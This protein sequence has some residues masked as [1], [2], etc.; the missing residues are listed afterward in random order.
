MLYIFFLSLPSSDLRPLTSDFCLPSFYSKDNISTK[1]WILIF[2]CSRDWAGSSI[3]SSRVGRPRP[4]RN[5]L[6]SG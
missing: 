5:C 1:A 2:I 6:R 4:S 3:S